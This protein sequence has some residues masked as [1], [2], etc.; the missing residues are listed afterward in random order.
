MLIVQVIHR[1]LDCGVWNLTCWILRFPRAVESDQHSIRTD[2]Q[3]CTLPA[4]LA[5]PRADWS[6]KGQLWSRKR[7][8]HLLGGLWPTQCSAGSSSLRSCFGKAVAKQVSWFS[9]R[10]RGQEGEIL[11]S[12]IIRVKKKTL[13]KEPGCIQESIFLWKHLRKL[14]YFKFL[15]CLPLKKH[16]FHFIM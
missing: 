5:L 3:A 16:V 6:G 14:C 12:K 7:V 10:L 2:L 9:A 4:V 11:Q 15:S 1:T 8:Q 13:K